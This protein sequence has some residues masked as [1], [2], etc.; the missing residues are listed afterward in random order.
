[1][2]DRANYDAVLAELRAERDVLDT[3]IE[4]LERMAAIPSAETRTSQPRTESAQAQELA[5]D[6]FFGMS[7]PDAIKKYLRIVKKKQSVNT[8]AKA[9]ED[10]GL[11]HASKSFYSTV[12]T[13]TRRMEVRGE[14]VQIGKDWGLADWYPGLKRGKTASLIAASEATSNEANDD[15]KDETD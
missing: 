2:A 1:M 15:T 13:V 9:L 11:Q 5:D 3:A 7:I 10:G 12:S 4:L 8:I 6:S 14:V